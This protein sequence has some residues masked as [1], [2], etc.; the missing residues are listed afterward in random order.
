MLLF[1]NYWIEKCTVKHWNV[2]SILKPHH[3]NV[4]S[5]MIIWEPK[6]PGTLWATPGLLRDCFNFTFVKSNLWL[7]KNKDCTCVGQSMII[8]FFS[9][10]YKLEI[11]YYSWFVSSSFLRDKSSRSYRYRAYC[12]KIAFPRTNLH[13]LPRWN[14]A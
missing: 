2:L 14:I 12:L 8:W 5:I 13:K 10:Y 6:P 11:L 3:L 1:I 4:P 7:N 9:L